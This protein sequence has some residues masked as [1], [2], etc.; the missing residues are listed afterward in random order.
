MAIATGKES[1]AGRDTAGQYVRSVAKRKERTRMGGFDY[2]LIVD[3]KRGEIFWE[4]LLDLAKQRRDPFDN[5]QY[6]YGLDWWEVKRPDCQ[7]YEGY[8]LESEEGGEVVLRPIPCELTPTLWEYFEVEP[9]EGRWI[10]YFP[11]IKWPFHWPSEFKKKVYD[12][13]ECYGCED[14]FLQILAAGIETADR[15]F[16]KL[17]SKLGNLGIEFRRSRG[18]Y[19]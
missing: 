7:Y 17:E 1:A 3:E 2:E 19:S 15:F 12:H 9:P 14:I 11:E 6:L 4:A 10:F 5:K 13:F 8:S 16:G 18:K